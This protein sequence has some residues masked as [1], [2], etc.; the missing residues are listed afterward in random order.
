[1]RVLPQA[2]FSPCP[3]CHQFIHPAAQLCPHCRASVHEET[4]LEPGELERVQHALAEIASRAGDPPDVTT[5]PAKIGLA[6][7]IFTVLFAVL[8]V[9]SIVSTGESKVILIVLTALVGILSIVTW[10]RDLGMPSV[11]KRTTGRDAIR[12]YMAAIRRGRWH[13]AFACL[14]PIART[15]EA[16]T[17]A[18]AELQTKWSKVRFDQPAGVKKFWTALVRPSGWL[19]RTISS[20]RIEPA[21]PATPDLERYRVTLKVDYYSQWIVLT[22]LVNII[23]CLVLYLVMRKTRELTFPLVVVKDRSQWWLVTGE[24]YA[25]IDR[26]LAAG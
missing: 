14:S 11:R 24:P 20:V 6:T 26:A 19:V 16:T 23:L 4:G 21:G 8:V 25:A 7:R 2:I 17:P 5:Q 18:I 22:V 3:K 15:R 12:C 9:A 13:H 10:I 1:V